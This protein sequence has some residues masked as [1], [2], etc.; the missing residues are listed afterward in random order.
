MMRSF[1]LIVK[2]AL[3]CCAL[4]SGANAQTFDADTPP[5]LNTL[6]HVP[7]TLQLGS[8]NLFAPRLGMRV[9]GAV[10]P[11]PLLVDRDLNAEL[12]ANV[13]YTLRGG[14]N[15]FLLSSDVALYAGLGPRYAIYQ[16]ELFLVDNEAGGYWGAGAMAG[17]EA[18]LGVL[19][20]RL[21][22][23]FAEAGVDFLW[24][25]GSSYQDGE[26]MPKVRLGLSL[27]FFTL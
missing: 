25:A 5:L 16:S 15:T 22:R 10:Y 19:G 23:A 24:P 21:A 1:K 8:D 2:V 27:P 9:G 13:T 17:A 18:N 4:F 12:F 11:L 20:F 3:F 14:V 7:L 6:A 26:V